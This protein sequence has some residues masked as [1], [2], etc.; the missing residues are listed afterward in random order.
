MAVRR[1]A[2]TATKARWWLATGSE[3]CPHCRHLYVEELIV[4]CAECDGPYCR[5]CRQRHVS[6]RYV[7]PDC[8][9]VEQARE[10]TRGG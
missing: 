3:E 10:Q 5:H 4:H 8:A 6:G 2:K 1:S 9:N 7:C